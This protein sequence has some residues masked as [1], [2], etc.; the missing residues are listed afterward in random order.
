MFAATDGADVAAE[1]T[2]LV[3]RSASLDRV[4]WSDCCDD[5]LSTAASPTISR[6]MSSSRRSA[7]VVV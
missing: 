2:V 6:M 1:G 4:D 3:G 5:P 7:V